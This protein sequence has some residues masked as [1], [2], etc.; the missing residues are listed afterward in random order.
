MTG[1][2]EQSGEEGGSSGGAASLPLEERPHWEDGAGRTADPLHASRPRRAGQQAMRPWSLPL[3]ELDSPLH[4]SKTPWP[5]WV[6]SPSP[7]SGACAHTAS[8]YPALHT[9]SGRLSPASPAPVTQAPVP[10]SAC[11]PVSP[12]PVLC[13][14]GCWSLLRSHAPAVSGPGS[15]CLSFKPRPPCICLRWSTV[16]NVRRRAPG[17][18]ALTARRASVRPGWLALLQPP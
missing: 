8:L 15:F 1:L 4:L 11:P 13:V 17:G 3:S 14:H 18:S 5:V 10:A 2:G 6:L 9:T 16:S 7:A 12:N